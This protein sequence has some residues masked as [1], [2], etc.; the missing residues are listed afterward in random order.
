M[1]TIPD[2]DLTQ[3]QKDRL[4]ALEN[5]DGRLTLRAVSQD[6]KS[7]TSP[8]YPCFEWNMR[9]AAEA[10]WRQTAID[11]ISSDLRWVLDPR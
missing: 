5:D 8:L 4:L 7:V 10:A 11:I 3:E 1:N 6:A 9:K 2:M